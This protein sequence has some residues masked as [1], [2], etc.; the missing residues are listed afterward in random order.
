METQWAWG[1]IGLVLILIEGSFLGLVFSLVGKKAFAVTQASYRIDAIVGVAACLVG[2]WVQMKAE[3]YAVEING[4]VVS[5]SVGGDWFGF[6][7]WIIDHYLSTQ[8]IITCL[9]VLFVWASRSYSGRHLR[10]Q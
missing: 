2:N 9:L 8:V 6:R 10:N 7:V 3:Q 4:K 1:A 5:F